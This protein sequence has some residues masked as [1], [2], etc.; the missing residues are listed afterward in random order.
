[1]RCGLEVQGAPARE[2]TAVYDAQG[3]K[4]VGEVRS[5]LFAPTLGH[6]IAQAWMLPSHMEPGTELKVRVRGRMQPAKVVPMPFV[7][8]VRLLSFPFGKLIR[9]S[10]KPFYRVPKTL[11]AEKVVCMCG[12][13]D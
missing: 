6:P 9:F 12:C 3:L 8:K 10:L 5:G 13:R 4:Q 1:M 2:Q 7:N 11:K